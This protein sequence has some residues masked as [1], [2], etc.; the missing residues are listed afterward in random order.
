MAFSS[1]VRITLAGEPT[2]SELSGN[3]LPSVTRAP[4][5]TSEFLPILAPLSTIAPMPIRLPSPM[6]QPCSSARW[7]IVQ[8]RPMVNGKPGSVCM[9]VCSWTLLSSPIS[10]RSLSPR[11]TTPNHTETLRPIPTFP[12][13]VA[14]GAI[15]LL[16]RSAKCRR[17]PVNR[18]N[19]HFFS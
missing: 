3:S 19:R 4:A 18:I 8:P 11:M 10:I 15:Q 13:I 9:I 12:M 16:A 7:P 1:S 2:I 5:P 17:L 14:S 6:V